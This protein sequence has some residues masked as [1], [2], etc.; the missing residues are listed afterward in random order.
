MIGAIIRGEQTLAF[1][2]GSEEQRKRERCFSS[3]KMRLGGIKMIGIV[4]RRVIAPLS[5]VGD[6]VS[7]VCDVR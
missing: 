7:R 6:S 5:C 2:R 1:V 3:A 4:W